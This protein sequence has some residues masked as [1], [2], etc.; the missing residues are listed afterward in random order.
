MAIESI[1][2]ATGKLLRSFEPL[3]DEAAREKIALAA[4]SFPAYSQVPLE[5]RSLW[6]R[7][8]ASLL[9][10]EI[11][12]L[13]T[14]ITQDMGKPIEAAHFEIL[15]GASFCRYYAEHAARILAP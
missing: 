14:L 5:H 3:T 12:D 8:L 7:K 1:N 2:P 9:E 15:K 10:H 4:E 13:A 6:M 11:E